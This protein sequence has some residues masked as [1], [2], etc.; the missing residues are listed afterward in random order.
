MLTPVFALQ[1][2]TRLIPDPAGTFEVRC[3]NG[4]RTVKGKCCGYCSYAPHAGYLTGDMARKHRCFEKE[5]VF[6][7]SCADTGDEARRAARR[8]AKTAEKEQ[9]RQAAGLADAVCA[10]TRGIEDFRAVRVE[11]DGAA[12]LVV[13]YASVF[14][15]DDRAV[16]A[17]V[18]DAVGRS[19]CLR[20]LRCDM[21]AAA[22]LIF[23]PEAAL[24]V[25]MG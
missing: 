6:L 3:I 25:Q 17:A 1:E 9:R 24:T 11:P 4:A 8:E 20:P 14:G 12:G 15:I 16:T 18:E 7:Y 19:V 10:A 5:C 21:A 13:W 23:G 22:R 2:E